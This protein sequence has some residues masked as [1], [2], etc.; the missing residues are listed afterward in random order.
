QVHLA[1]AVDLDEKGL[2]APVI[3]NA[4]NLNLRGMAKAVKDIGTAAKKGTLTPDQLQ[5][6]TFTLTSPG[7]LGSFASAPIINQPNV[8]IMATDG[9][10]RKPTVVGD[11]IAIHHMGVLGLCYDHR[12]FDG[13]TAARFLDH[14]R[15]ALQEWNW[16]PEIG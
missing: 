3:R 12:A 11:A 1:V 10:S 8:A 6:S 15:R 2:M 13:M 9:V 7:P 14:V 4:D 16:E 5:G